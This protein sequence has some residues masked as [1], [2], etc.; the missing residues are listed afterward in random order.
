MSF[1]SVEV[2]LTFCEYLQSLCQQTQTPK[3]KKHETKPPLFY[4]EVRS[5]EML[6]FGVTLRNDTVM[7]V[8]VQRLQMTHKTEK[9]SCNVGS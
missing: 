5:V 2:S 8:C 3:H 4:K 1:S 6:F 9:S 7:R